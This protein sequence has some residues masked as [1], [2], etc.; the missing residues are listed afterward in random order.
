[1]TASKMRQVQHAVFHRK[2]GVECCMEITEINLTECPQH[3]ILCAISVTNQRLYRPTNL[4][5]SVF[6]CLIARTCVCECVC[7]RSYAHGCMHACSCVCKC[8]VQALGTAKTMRNYTMYA[9]RVRSFV[10]AFVALRVLFHQPIV[11]VMLDDWLSICFISYVILSL[12]YLI[13]ILSFRYLHRQ[14][15]PPN[16]C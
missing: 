1:M 15:H 14:I 10:Q 16:L 3:S 13:H 6:V 11:A 7:V 9:K 5:V 2:C 8:T 4:C 12:V